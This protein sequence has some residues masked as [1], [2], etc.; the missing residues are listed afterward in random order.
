MST[1]AAENNQ[2]GKS[3]TE[4]QPRGTALIP[5]LVFIVIYMGVGLVLQFSDV[6]MAFYQ[7]PAPVAALIGIAVAFVIFRGTV[8]EKVEQFMAGCG[9]SNIMT[10]CCIYMLAGGFAALAKAMGGVQATANPGLSI[11]PPEYITAGLFVIAAFLSLATGTSVGTITAIGPI[12]I[13][14][15]SQAGLNLVLVLGTVV[16]GAMFGD[17]L[18]MISDTTIAATRTQGVEM[19]D[20]FRVNFMMALPA[21]LLTFGLLL[22]LGRPETV[23]PLRELEFSIIKVVP[24][25]WILAL[26]LLGVNVFVTLASGILVALAVGVF[27]GDLTLLGSAQSVYAGFTGMFEVFLLS[28]FIGGLSEMVTRNGGLLWML[29]KIQSKVTSQRSAEIGISSLVSIADI[30]T[31]NNTV[32]IVVS[33]SIAKNIADRY[34]VDPRRSASLLDT[35]SCVFQGILPYGAQTLIICGLAAGVVSP[36]QLLATLWYPYLLGVFALVSTFV[37]FADGY[38]RKNPW[39][40]AAGRA[41]KQS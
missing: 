40:W 30:A 32:A 24:Y 4:I 26:S 36:F 35:W 34:R 37:P 9:H 2:A 28:M 6:E 13:E 14:V 11:I 16:G 39:N 19:R 7:M 8:D 12:A 1:P 27:S 21:A 17:N 25:I 41:E 23:V 15:A 22:L 3:Q 38:I 10:M 20:K 5:F 31:A 29:Q 33:G 18:S